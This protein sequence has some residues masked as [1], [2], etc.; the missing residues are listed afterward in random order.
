MSYD[1]CVRAHAGCWQKHLANM[2]DEKIAEAREAVQLYKEQEEL[3]KQGLLPPE[4]EE[5]EGEEEADAMEAMLD[6][7]IT[8]IAIGVGVVAAAAIFYVGVTTG[9]GDPAW[10]ADA[11]EL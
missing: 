8:Y 7:A 5:G 11:K 9:F 1:L 6:K 3:R 10:H 2:S 4:G